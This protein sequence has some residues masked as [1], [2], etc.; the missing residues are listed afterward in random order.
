MCTTSHS[1][2]VYSV[3]PGRSEVCLAQIKSLAVLTV[4]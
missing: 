3:N 2:V 1:A 4:H